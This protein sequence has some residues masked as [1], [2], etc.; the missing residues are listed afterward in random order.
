MA[1]V[2]VLLEVGLFLFV[3]LDPG[4]QV[5][6]VGR[7]ELPSEGPGG[8]VV[9]TLEGDQPVFDLVKAGE[10]VGC[11]DLALHDGEKDLRLIQ[12]GRVRGSVHHHRVRKPRGEPVGGGLAA[13]GGAVVDDPEH[14]SRAGVRLAGHHLG[15]KGGEGFDAVE[16]AQ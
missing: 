10:V 7:G 15:D 2:I 3:S 8:L 9:T 12:P 1:A 14:S 5:L 6:E 16:G 13:M 4:Q 11:D